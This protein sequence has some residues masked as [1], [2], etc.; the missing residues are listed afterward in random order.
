MGVAVDRMGFGVQ[1]R[2]AYSEVGQFADRGTA[3]LGAA[4]ATRV[5][6][7]ESVR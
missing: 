2:Q 5:H 7:L 6:P 3:S 4:N 1:M